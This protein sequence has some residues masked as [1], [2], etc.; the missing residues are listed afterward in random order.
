MFKSTNEANL[1][2]KRCYYFKIE[3]MYISAVKTQLQAIEEVRK[4]EQLMI[5]TSVDYLS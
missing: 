4:D 1:T 2:I 3:A 5:P